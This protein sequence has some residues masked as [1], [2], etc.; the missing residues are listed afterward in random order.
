MLLHCRGLHSQC[1]LAFAL[2][3]WPATVLLSCLDRL[4]LPGLRIDPRFYRLVPREISRG[5]RI[6]CPGSRP[7]PA[8][9]DLLGGTPALAAKTPP[10]YLVFQAGQSDD[11]GAF[12][13]AILRTMGPE[14]LGTLASTLDRFLDSHF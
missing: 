12:P 7:S 14:D 11:W 13:S 5:D 1:S 10:A 4:G 6:Q 3:K 8:S 9:A 2:G